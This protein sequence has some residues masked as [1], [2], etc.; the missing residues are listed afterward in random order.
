MLR[1]LSEHIAHLE[2]KIEAFK[3]ALA[4]PALNDA[5]RVDLRLDLD[6]AERAL[7]HFRKAFE[8]EQRLSFR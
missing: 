4:A 5:E 1:P 7:A 8:L 3:S 6:L 2:Q